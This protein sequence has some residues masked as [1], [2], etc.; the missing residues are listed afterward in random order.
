MVI[1]STF[2]L[3]VAFTRQFSRNRFH[4]R[5]CFWLMLANIHTPLCLWSM[6]V[7]FVAHLSSFFLYRLA[8]YHFRVGCLCCNTL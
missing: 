7:M 1:G 3:A 2:V 8:P 6:L 5:A 4:T